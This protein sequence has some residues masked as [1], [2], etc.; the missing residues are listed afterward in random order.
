MTITSLNTGKIIGYSTENDTGYLLESTNDTKIFCTLKP[1]MA[2]QEIEKMII[3]DKQRLVFVINENDVYNS[4][5]EIIEMIHNFGFEVAFRISFCSFPGLITI[6][7]WN[8]SFIILDRSVVNHMK[9]N[10]DFVHKVNSVVIFGRELNYTVI[11]EGIDS[12]KELQDVI[13]IG[14]PDGSGIIFY[15]DR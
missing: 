2:A 7:R 14:I 12:K 5:D 11:A 10:I 8:P 13:D 1:E 15:S 3:C 9:D 4:L 6:K